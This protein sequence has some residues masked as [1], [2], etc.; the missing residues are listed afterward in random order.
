MPICA[1]VSLLL[2][3][4]PLKKVM[5]TGSKQL[6]AGGVGVWFEIVWPHLLRA[7]GYVPDVWAPWKNTGLCN[8]EIAV[9][10]L[11]RTT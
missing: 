4:S 8:F 6:F 2:T 3:L 1:S 9:F 11:L 7:A 5:K 10:T